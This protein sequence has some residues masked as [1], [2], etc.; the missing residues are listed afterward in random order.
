MKIFTMSS[1]QSAIIINDGFAI[2]QR[3]NKEKSSDDGNRK[4]YPVGT[5]NLDKAKTQY[6]FLSKSFQE[7]II[8]DDLQRLDYLIFKPHT[9]IPNLLIAFPNH[10]DTSAMLVFDGYK[11]NDITFINS[12]NYEEAPCPY[13]GKVS[14]AYSCDAEYDDVFHCV[15]CK[16]RGEVVYTENDAVEL[17]HEMGLDPNIKSKKLVNKFFHLN[18]GVVRI[19]EASTTCK[20]E[21]FLDTFSVVIPDGGSV[22]FLLNRREKNAETG[23]ESQKQYLV[24]FTHMIN[25]NPSISMILMNERGFTREQYDA[26][27]TSA[28]NFQENLKSNI[29]HTPKP[30]QTVFYFPDKT[31]DESP[32]ASLKDMLPKNEE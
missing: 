17:A 22:Q 4:T 25:Q 28:N 31:D 27:V 3:F 8:E 23:Y 20:V 1:D 12:N 5:Y 30:K 19:Y 26:I 7:Q 13:D 2:S 29:Q 21:N 32:F 9:N 10:K 16:E 15:F 24:E 18:H 14:K 6:F 11:K